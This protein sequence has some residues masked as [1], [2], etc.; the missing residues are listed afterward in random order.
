MDYMNKIISRWESHGLGVSHTS[1]IVWNATD[2]ECSD[3][4]SLRKIRCSGEW[5]CVSCVKAQL[6]AHLPKRP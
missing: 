4:C 5:P 2:E 3:V 1:V 6:I